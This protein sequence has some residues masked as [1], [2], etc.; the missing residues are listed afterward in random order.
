MEII[1]VTSRKRETYNVQLAYSPL[2]ECA[3]GIAAITNTPLINTLEKPLIY[4]DEL[5]EALSSNLLNH[6][7]YVEK[8]NTWKAILQLLHYKEISSLKNFISIVKSLDSTELKFICLPF[9][10]DKHD[11]LR[12]NAALG[13]L[14]LNKYIIL[15]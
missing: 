15:F 8:N 5:K 9:I 3:L 13:D 1:H 10:G 7:E 4:W 2:W 6:L 12:K 11:D 14:Q